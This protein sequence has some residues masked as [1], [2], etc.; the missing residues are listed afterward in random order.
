MILYVLHSAGWMAELDGCRRRK[1]VTCSSFSLFSFQL[2]LL[3]ILLGVAPI[4]TGASKCAGLHCS[5]KIGD[6][7]KVRER[8][9]RV[10]GWVGGGNGWKNRVEKEL[11]RTYLY[12]GRIRRRRL[13]SLVCFR[14]FF[15]FSVASVAPPPLARKISSRALISWDRSRV[16]DTSS[17]AA[18]DDFFFANR[19][20]QMPNS[21]LLRPLDGNQ[22]SRHC[23]L[24]CTCIW[25]I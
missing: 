20:S 6:N 13:I 18:R 3:S 22:D 1:N 12:R 8:G 25:W 5:A 11:Y 14:P 19:H 21:A 16:F 23:I 7:R 15:S 2:L 17:R 10:D 4:L 24:L 9:C